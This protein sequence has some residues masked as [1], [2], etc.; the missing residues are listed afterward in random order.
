MKYEVNG[1]NG[2]DF[3]NDSHRHTYENESY[4]HETDFSDGKL[5][6][7]L[8]ESRNETKLFQG[9]TEKGQKSLEEV[10]AKQRRQKRK[11][12]KKKDKKQKK[13][14]K[15]K[16]E[17]PPQ[18]PFH[19]LFRYANCTDYLLMLV[20]TLGAMVHGAA[21]PFMMTVFG[22]MIDTFIEYSRC[23]EYTGKQCTEEDI[24]AT[25]EAQNLTYETLNESQK[26]YPIDVEAELTSFSYY[27]VFIACMVIVCGYVQVGNWV[28]AS[29]RQT[30]KIRQLFFR[31]IMRQEIGWFDIH[32]MGE[33]NTRMSDDVNKISDAIA[34]KFSVFIQRLTTFVGGFV[35]GFVNGWELTLVIMAISPLL[36]IGAALM[37][38]FVANMTSK[39][40]QAYAAA[41]SVAEEVL[42]SI[43]TVAAFGGEKKEVERYDKNLE[44]AEKQGIKKGMTQGFFSGYM[45]CMIFLSYALA[46]WYGSTLVLDERFTTG[47]LMTVFFAVLIGAINLGQAAPN[48]EAFSVGKSAAAL[49]YQIIERESKID[50]FSKE[51][52]VLDHVV[53][54]IELHD[55]DFSYPSRDDQLI[56]DNLR[57][58]FKAGETTAI[59][60]PSG[61]GKSTILQLVQRFYDPDKGVVTLDGH[62]LRTLNTQ[63][64]RKMIGIVQ[65][66]PS[67]FATTI[68]ENIRFG[69]EGVTDEEIIQAAKAANAYNFIMDLPNKFQTQVGTGGG[70]MSGGQKQ[71]IAIARALIRNPKILLLDQA[72]SALDTQSEAIVLEEL[73]KARKGRT[74]I[75]V[76]HR[77]STIRNADI[78]VGIEH[79][80]AVER[81]THEE[82]MKNNGVY[83]TLVTLQTTKRKKSECNDGD[84]SDSDTEGT[85]DADKDDEI[86]ENGPEVPLEH[87][88]GMGH[89]RSFRRSLRKRAET[90][91]STGDDI[92]PITM[93][94]PTT[95]RKYEIT[96]RKR[97]DSDSEESDSSSESEA[98]D[99][100]VEA[101]EPA[102]LNRIM[103]LNSTEWPYIVAGTI[104]SAVNGAIQPVFAILFS[105]LLGVFSSTDPQEIQEGVNF[106]ALLFVGIAVVSF[107]TYFLQNYMFAKSGEILTRR[108]RKMGFECMLRQDIGW[109]DDHRNNPGALSTRLATDAAYV[110][111][112][113]GA[114]IGII[115]S[116]IASIGS[117]LIIAFTFGWK[118]A[119]VV[120]AFL[121]LI[122][123]SG[124]IQA[125][126]MTGS[127]KRDKDSLEEAS[128]V[129]S[130]AIESIRTVVSLNKEEYFTQKYNEVLIGPYKDGKTNSQIYGLTFGIANSIIFFAYAASFRFGGYLVATGEMEFQYVF[131]V[132]SAIVFGGTALGRASNYAPDY[133]KARTSAARIFQLF[134]RKPSIDSYSTEGDKWKDFKGEIEFRDCKFTYPTR[135]DITVLRG[136]N[137]SIGSGE[138][139]ALVGQSGCGKSTSVQLLERFYDPDEGIVLVDG[140]ETAKTNVGFLRSK[141]G[142][143]SQ[144]PVLFGGTVYDNIIYGDNGREVPK[145]DVERAA[146]L[147]NMHEFILA[148]KDGYHTEVGDK[149]D[150]LSRGQK[151]RVAIARALVRSPRI[152]LLDEATSALDTESEK[153]VQEALDRAREGRTCIVIAHRLSTIKNADKIAVISQGQVIEQGN[154]DYLMSIEGAYYKL[155]T[156]NASLS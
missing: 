147:A 140:H 141:I 65:Q 56:L 43:R 132:F 33:L 135:Q 26:Y 39:E 27:Y 30:R 45:W 50:P 69:R 31:S 134:D 149:G 57:I 22:Q 82:L 136:L 77:L 121:P 11:K 86:L 90:H 20:G 156:T 93:T 8:D 118:L 13:K 42:S 40:L 107:I 3:H 150:Q 19:K 111:G 110:K 109:Y 24:N 25:Y 53:G 119:F 55:C 123:F 16:F 34:D 92:T 7:T 116:A 129:V 48:L 21:F 71:R 125:R 87:V 59:V 113:T 72:C 73:D 54:D 155:V 85:S 32:H 94:T 60:G 18:V 12:Q 2:T 23:V 76:A 63:W 61:M 95:V 66:E 38:R 139:L 4:M 151:Q 117:A 91:M 120:V 47:Q 6:K 89:R 100:E 103:K 1:K 148:L 146:R 35:V 115:V 49:V 153:I 98:E 14:K 58:T 81:G 106:Y 84:V 128:T 104:G 114:Q 28:L 15:K 70:H 97:H 9:N 96:A 88:T 41:G 62:D 130:E 99:E 112:A 36:G 127:A 75:I 105:G 46:F 80:K 131:R 144:E 74:T 152:L 51:G 102:P 138:T 101:I 52:H 142:V 64:L 44:S 37:G 143:V 17:K 78:I 5:S 29:T 83:Y 124:L 108:L 68:A 137:V 145:E 67:L 154:H 10:V 126:L 79:G 122:V 133:A